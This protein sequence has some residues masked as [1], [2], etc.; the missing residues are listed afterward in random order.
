[1]ELIP[2]PAVPEVTLCPVFIIS[3]FNLA[4][5][6]RDPL[7]ILLEFIA[8]VSAMDKESHLISSRAR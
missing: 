1:M 3:I 4:F 5:K 6:Y 8:E 2:I 7:H